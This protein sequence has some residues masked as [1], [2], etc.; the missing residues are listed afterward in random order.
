MQ[1]KIYRQKFSF[2][3]IKVFQ[4]I[5]ALKVKDKIPIVSTLKEIETLLFEITTCRTVINDKSIYSTLHVPL[6]DLNGF[7]QSE[8]LNS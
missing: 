1:V 8:F 4:K 6:L 5:Q 2:P 7:N 3:I